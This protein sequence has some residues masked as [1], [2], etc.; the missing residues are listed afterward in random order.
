MSFFIFG[1]LSNDK[2]ISGLSYPQTKSY[3]LHWAHKCQLHLLFESD[4]KNTIVLDMLN[5]QSM[6]RARYT[7]FLMTKNKVD[8]TSDE[9]I[10]PFISINK[11][12]SPLEHTLE[13]I[14]LISDFLLTA[15]NEDSARKASI[16]LLFTEGYDTEFKNHDLRVDQFKPFMQKIVSTE[17]DIPSI[18]L[19]IMH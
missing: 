15:F 16:S 18:R 14:R 13:G 4:I 8:T 12:A 6:T 2:P 10:S 5:E 19:N 7:R 11:G 9:L 3:L 17:L 1:A